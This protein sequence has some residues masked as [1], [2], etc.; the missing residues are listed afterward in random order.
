MFLLDPRQFVELYST[1]LAPVFLSQNCRFKFHKRRQFFI[2]MDNQTL[3][4]AA[5][6]V[7]NPDE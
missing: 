2:R 5:M 7:S 1:A 6:R 4:I 3:P